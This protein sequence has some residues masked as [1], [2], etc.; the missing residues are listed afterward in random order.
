VL[1]MAPTEV[2]YLIGRGCIGYWAKA[3]SLVGES[4]DSFRGNSGHHGTTASWQ[5]M[6]H[7]RHSTKNYRTTAS[8]R[9]KTDIATGLH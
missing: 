3:D 9:A 4:R 8:S 5:L 1:M 2:Q 6:T 7:K